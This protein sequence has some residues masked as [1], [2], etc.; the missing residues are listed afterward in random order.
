MSSERTHLPCDSKSHIQASAGTPPEMTDV[1]ENTGQERNAPG[2]PFTLHVF[3]HK[4]VPRV[5]G[6]DAKLSFQ[7]GAG[8]R[9]RVCNPDTPTSVVLP[10]H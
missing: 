7:E 9:R 6:A 2:S 5:G 1:D 10:C 4:N 8:Q 3:S